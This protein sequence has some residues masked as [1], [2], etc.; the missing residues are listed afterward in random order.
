L[1]CVNVF[2]LWHT[3]RNLNTEEVTTQHRVRRVRMHSG[4]YF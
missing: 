3:L 1:L 2:S 4:V